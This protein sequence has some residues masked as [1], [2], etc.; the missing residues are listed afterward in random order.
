MAVQTITLEQ[1]PMDIAAQARGLSAGRMKFLR[2]VGNTMV[3][4]VKMRLLSGKGVDQ[5]PLKSWAK[6]TKFA[7]RFS[8]A[9]NVRPSGRPVTV[10]SKRLL[11]TRQLANSY[12]IVGESMNHVA[13]GP[14]GERNSVIAEN[15]AEHG[16]DL[17]GWDDQTIGMI[18]REMDAWLTNVAM[19]TDWLPPSSV[20][21]ILGG[22]VE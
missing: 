16:N 2:F 15:E 17:V 9:Y 21:Q 19:G 22:G 8:L 14:R 11:D 3:K 12:Q 7:D 1:L 10:A 13:V 18:E 4:F 5:K 20:G 6:D